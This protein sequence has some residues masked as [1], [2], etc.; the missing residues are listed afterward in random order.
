MAQ[1]RS[2]AMLIALGL[3]GMAY[4]AQQPAPAPPDAADTQ[5]APPTTPDAQSTQM[6]TP[7]QK[8]SMGQQTLQGNMAASPKIVGMAV[9]SPTGEVLGSV[10]DVTMDSSRQP[11]YVV[12]SSGNDT[13][14]AVPYAAVN[15]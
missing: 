4:G 3:A 9:L 12:I 6:P 10:I 2:I 15:A 13:M 7:H 1:L 11:E 8:G 5:A 14:T